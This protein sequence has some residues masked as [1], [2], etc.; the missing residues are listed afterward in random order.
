MAFCDPTELT[1]VEGGLAGK[2][3]NLG[4]GIID[5]ST[6][7]IR[8]FPFDDTNTFSMANPSLGVAAG[9][10][11]AAVMA[12]VPSGQARGFALTKQG[13]DWLVRN[14]SHL[15]APDGQ[16][17]PTRMNPQTFDEVVAA[18]RAAGAQPLF[19]R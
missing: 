6:G 14:Q 16:P 15:N 8:L 3:N 7:T 11:S 9:H 18:L 12:G 5:L 4:V 2:P 1:N 10:E 17:N 13:N 19:I